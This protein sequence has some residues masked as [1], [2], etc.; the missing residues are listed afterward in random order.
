MHGLYVITDASVM[1]PDLLYQQVSECIDG[2][3]SY[4]Q[5][6]HKNTD[7]GLKYALA[8]AVD[9]ACRIKEI[10]LLINDDTK[11][12]LDIG[13]TGVHLGQ[14]DGALID[15]RIALGKSAIIGRTCHDSP[16]LMK[17]AIADGAS[18]CAF[19]RLFQSQTK[20][21]APVLPLDALSELAKQCT[22]PVVAIGGITC[23]N[24]RA[25][26]DTG[27]AILAVSG[28]I[29]RTSDIGEASRCLA[30]LF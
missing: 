24:G 16:A 8:D 7:S 20:P 4:I 25:V 22:I 2:G 30:E 9:E 26:L 28:A 5:F 19:G 3:A 27:V 18:Y 23:E 29:F 6:R 15:S 14:S 12:A 17:K 13:S 10:P 1:D 11:L 21:N